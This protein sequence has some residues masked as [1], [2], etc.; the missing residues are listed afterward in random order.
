MY[1]DEVDDYMYLYGFMM[2]FCGDVSHIHGIEDH[3]TYRIIQ[4]LNLL[5]QLDHG[6]TF[7]VSN[8]RL[9][10]H[11]K[12]VLSTDTAIP[13]LYPLV[14]PGFKFLLNCLVESSHRNIQ[15][16]IAVAHMAVAD[17]VHHGMRVIFAYQASFGE[18]FPRFVDKVVQFMNGY[19]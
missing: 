3:L 10:G 2:P 4:V 12:T 8:V 11:A 1:C 6:L 13:L 7:A 5:H 18:A 16:K 17:D 14:D 9:L 15:V 19:R